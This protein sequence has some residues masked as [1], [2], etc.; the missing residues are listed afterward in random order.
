MSSVRL[1][2]VLSES[3]LL[4]HCITSASTGIIWH[5]TKSIQAG[6]RRLKNS[7]Q[8]IGRSLLAKYN[9]MAE[10]NNNI[11]RIAHFHQGIS[12]VVCSLMELG[13]FFCCV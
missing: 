9:Y 1:L 4:K 3:K 10:N 6:L 12:L 8:S 2:V 13:L 7:L 11:E 5:C